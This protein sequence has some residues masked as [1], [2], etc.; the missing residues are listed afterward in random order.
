MT[1]Y[2]VRPKPCDLLLGRGTE[3][4]MLGQTFQQREREYSIYHPD[5]GIT[6]KHRQAILAQDWL[7]CYESNVQEQNCK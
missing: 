7:S 3:R 2:T 5:S 4:S 1:E 6:W